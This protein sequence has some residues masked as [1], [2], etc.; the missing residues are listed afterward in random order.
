MPQADLLAEFRGTY[1]RMCVL[2]AIALGKGYKQDAVVQAAAG[3]GTS[4]ALTFRKLRNQHRLVCNVLQR[5][6]EAGVLDP[7]LLKAA[8]QA[9]TAVQQE[10]ACQIPVLKLH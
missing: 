7:D 9:R 3:E 2:V 8:Q 5:C 4:F 6:K 10:F 1:G